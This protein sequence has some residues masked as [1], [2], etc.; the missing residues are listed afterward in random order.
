MGPL[1]AGATMTTTF[2]R[3]MQRRKRCVYS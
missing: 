3:C 2:K 1:D